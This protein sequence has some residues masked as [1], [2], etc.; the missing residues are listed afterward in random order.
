M[1]RRYARGDEGVGG[2]IW[3][4]RKATC[5][6]M[7]CEPSAARGQVAAPA[8]PLPSQR[9]LYLLVAWSPHLEMITPLRFLLPWT[10]SEFGFTDAQFEVPVSLGGDVHGA[11]GRAPEVRQE[12]WDPDSILSSRLAEMV[13]NI[14]GSWK[15]WWGKGLVVG[16]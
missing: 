8:Q 3:E 14:P 15:A 9:R 13:V 5:C 6:E 10:S 4:Q 11:A 16:A 7:G 2:E 12:G 1:L